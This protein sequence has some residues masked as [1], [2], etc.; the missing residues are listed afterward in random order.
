MPIAQQRNVDICSYLHF[1]Q[2]SFQGQ[3]QDGKE[4]VPVRGSKMVCSARTK[5][6]RAELLNQ[7]GQKTI[8]TQRILTGLQI[9]TEH[10]VHQ[11][12]PGYRHSVV[13][14]WAQN[15]QDAEENRATTL[16]STGFW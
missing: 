13:K 5:D 11:V 14:K 1:R 16:P 4:G 2:H 15:S 8:Y 12:Q 9:L 6:S 3:D 7:V 10:V